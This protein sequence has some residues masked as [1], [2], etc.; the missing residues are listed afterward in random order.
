MAEGPSECWQHHPAIPWLASTRA[1][2][3]IAE[4]PSECWQH[5][6]A[7]PWLAS[8]RARII[9]AE[10]P[11]ECWQHHPAIPWLA[12]TRARIV[13]AEGPSECWQHHPAIPWLAS[14]RARIVMA[15]GPSECWQHHPA[16][17]WLASTRARIVMAEGPSECWQHHP[18]IPWL[19]STRAR[20]VIAEGP[21]ECW[22]RPPHHSALSF[23]PVAAHSGLDAANRAQNFVI[24]RGGKGGWSTLVELA[25][26]PS[27]SP[28]VGFSGLDASSILQLESWPRRSQA[29]IVGQINAQMP[30]LRTMQHCL[31]PDRAL[32]SQGRSE[33]TSCTCSLPR[34]PAVCH[35]TVCQ[36][37][38]GR[39][40]PLDKHGP[41]IA[42][43][44]EPLD[45]LAYA[46][47]HNVPWVWFSWSLVTQILLVSL[48]VAKVLII[49]SLR[50]PFTARFCT[51][52]SVEL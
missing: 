19:A 52:C 16:I 17:P 9:M 7:I 46:T 31:H 18:A 11:S 28:V 20:T 47:H 42:K 26:S 10:G 27:C 1:R 5:H 15:E 3:V 12:S 38:A 36:L 29:K 14:T 43:V 32:H 30:A 4:G 40:S 45:A 21:S 25:E 48:D 24:A 33:T 23:S 22:Q 6:P 13:M 8:T 41:K 49:K 34:C 35:G 50:L 39:N 44:S 2:T 51:D 37:A